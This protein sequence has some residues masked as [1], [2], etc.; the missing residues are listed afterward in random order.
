MD[1]NFKEP[2]CLNLKISLVS[3]LLASRQPL[4]YELRFLLFNDT[5]IK[6]INHN[7]HV[8]RAIWLNCD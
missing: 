8:Q 6:L 7:H 2:D 3:I 4:Y 5:I 1:R